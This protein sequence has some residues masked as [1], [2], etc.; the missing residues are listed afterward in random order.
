MSTLCVHSPSPPVTPSSS[1]SLLLSLFVSPLSLSLSSSRGLSSS[2]PLQ[3][4]TFQPIAYRVRLQCAGVHLPHSIPDDTPA[5]PNRRP[6]AVSYLPCR[7]LR[8]R[9]RCPTPG[10]ETR[11]RCKPLK[12]ALPKFLMSLYIYRERDSP[13]LSLLSVFISRFP[14]LSPLLLCE[15]PR[16]TF[17]VML[18]ALIGRVNY[19]GSLSS[20]CFVQRISPSYSN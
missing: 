2:I 16:P 18:V 13:R 6:P 17:I 7:S 12:C 9:D 8:W 3:L 14:L 10:D 1:F 19:G 5:A 20:L 15:R 11:A 4:C